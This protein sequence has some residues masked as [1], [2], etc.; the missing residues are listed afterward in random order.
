MDCIKKA[1][2]DCEDAGGL[3]VVT[4]VTCYVICFPVE[5]ASSSFQENEE[6]LELPTFTP[7]LLDKTLNI[8]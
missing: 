7:E 6:Q 5:R 1:S 4:C 8:N 2:D 3:A